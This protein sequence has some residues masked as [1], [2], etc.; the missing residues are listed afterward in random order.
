MRIGLT[1]AGLIT[2]RVFLSV[3][4]AG[5]VVLVGAIGAARAADDLAKPLREA[6][7][8]LAAGDYATAYALYRKH[9]E[10][11]GNPLASFSLALFYQNGWG[12][13]A[14][15]VAACT[16]FEKSAAG[17]IPAGEH[18]AGDCIRRGV[19]RAADAT[20]AARLYERA[21]AGGHLGSLCS[22]AELYVAGE[23]VAKDPAKGL[24]LCHQAAQQGVKPAQVRLARFLI[25]GV[26]GKPDYPQ[27]LKIL[28]S[29]AQTDYAEAQFLLGGMLRDG[30]GAKPNADLAVS[31]FERAASQGYLPAYLPTARLYYGAAR[32]PKFKLLAPPHLAKAY[33][34]AS[35]FERRVNDAQEKTQAAGLLLKVRAEMPPTWA[36]DLDKKVDAHIAAVTAPPVQPGR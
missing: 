31:M 7:S 32:D 3:C 22:L 28:H 10:D 24:A 5:C 26:T 9:A 19:H 17:K 18:F 23:G 11:A 12:R 15:A 35:A 8:A 34:W 21:A 25:D 13:P 29:V 14:D 27:A 1:S 30:K 4:T 16:W 33:L 2:R 6:Q 20:A 36:A